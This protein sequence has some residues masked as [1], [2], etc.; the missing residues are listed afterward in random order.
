ML[1]CYLCGLETCYTSYFCEG[2]SYI[3][4]VLN[5][6]GRDQVKEI[7]TKTCIRNPQQIQ[8]KIDI[9]N[10][11]TEYD[12]EDSSYNLRTRQPNKTT[13]PLPSL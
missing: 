13:K 9:L 7:I 6:Y 2:C 8:N 1:T 12:T 4:R 3:K 10:K 11:K 5:V